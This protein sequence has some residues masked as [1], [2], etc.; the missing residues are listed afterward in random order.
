VSPDVPLPNIVWAE[1]H[2]SRVAYTKKRSHP[3]A[4]TDLEH[5]ENWDGFET[6][7]IDAIT[8]RMVAQIIIPE[9][10]YN[11]IHKS[12]GTRRTF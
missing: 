4:H 1:D 6:D 10:E 5:L 7:I 2:S 9:T 11:G 3:L 8:A 12:C